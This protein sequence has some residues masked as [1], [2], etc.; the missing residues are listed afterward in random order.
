MAKEK[1]KAT[2]G[3]ETTVPTGE[4]N[5]QEYAAHR[6]TRRDECGAKINE[7]LKEYGVDLS[8]KMIIGPGEIVPQVILID[9]RPQG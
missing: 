1:N 5:P 8:A 2:E 7:L 4:M 3:E 6:K 9:A